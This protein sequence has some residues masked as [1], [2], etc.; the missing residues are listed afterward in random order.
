MTITVL[1]SFFRKQPPVTIKYR[2]YKNF[3]KKTFHNELSRNLGNNSEINYDTFENTFMDQLNRHV[4]IK[5]KIVRANNAPYMNKTLAKAVTIRSTLRNKYLKLP[6]DINNAAY[7]K[8]RN[9]CVKL[10]KT[11]KKKYY[12][13]LDNTSI[14]DYINLWKTI[15]PCFSDNRIGQ[16]KI[17]LVE[18]E[19]FSFA[20]MNTED[21]VTV[22]KLMNINK[23]PTHNNINSDI[24]STQVK[25]IMI[26]YLI[27][28]FPNAL[29]N[30][31]ITPATKK[32]K[33]P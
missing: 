20:K 24:C 6:T 31:D 9:Y 33:L 5:S 17:V 15:K 14:T 29:K 1:K 13:N 27:T 23:P 30:A 21:V 22:L 25:F 18:N 11:E 32:M 12:N 7:K 3:D 8:H 28:C 26:L 4:P 19:H 2:N 10:F 16:Q